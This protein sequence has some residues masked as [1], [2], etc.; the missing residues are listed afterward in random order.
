MAN[1]KHPPIHDTQ[2]EL[3]RVNSQI[4]EVEREVN[5]AEKKLSVRERQMRVLMSCLGD[6]RAELREEEIV[7]TSL[8]NEVEEEEVNEGEVVEESAQPPAKKRKR[9]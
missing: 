1:E 4:Q 6:L 7:G 9:L 8:E 2:S 3:E 5:E